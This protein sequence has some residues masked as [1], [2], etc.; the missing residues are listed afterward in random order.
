MWTTSM[1]NSLDKSRL[2]GGCPPR[3]L[4]VVPCVVL[5]LN[6]AM[7]DPLRGVDAR[8][9]GPPPDERTALSYV[10]TAPYSHQFMTAQLVQLMSQVVATIH[11][12]IERDAAQHDAVAV[13]HNRLRDQQLPAI[14]AR[15]PHPTVAPTDSR[16]SPPRNRWP[17]PE[18]SSLLTRPPA[19]PSQAEQD[20]SPTSRVA[21]ANLTPT[22]PQ[23][24]TAVPSSSPL[25]DRTLAS[26]AQAPCPTNQRAEA[27]TPTSRHITADP[28]S[29]AAASPS[30]ARTPITAAPTMIPAPPPSPAAPLN[31]PPLVTASASPRPPT[32]DCTQVTPQPTGPANATAANHRRISSNHLPTRLCSHADAPPIQPSEATTDKPTA[33]GPAPPAATCGTTNRHAHCTTTTDNTGR[34]SKYA[35]LLDKLKAERERDLTFVISPADHRDRRTTSSPA[36]PTTSTRTRPTPAAPALQV[37]DGCVPFT[38]PPTPLTTQYAAPSDSKYTS[39]ESS[40][41]TTVRPRHHTDNRPLTAP[42]AAT[43]STVTFPVQPSRY[44]PIAEEDDED[45][46]T[47]V[48]NNDRWTT[49]WYE[50]LP[51]AI[52]IGVALERAVETALPPTFPRDIILEIISGA[53]PG[54]K[55][56][57]A[58]IDEAYDKLGVGRYVYVPPPGVNAD[59]DDDPDD[60]DKKDIDHRPEVRE[61]V[62][63]S[64]VDCVDSSTWG[65]SLNG[66]GCTVDDNWLVPGLQSD[67]SGITALMASSGAVCTRLVLQAVTPLPRSLRAAIVGYLGYGAV[68]CATGRTAEALPNS[69]P[70]A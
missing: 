29:S 52:Q 9:H 31:A 6:C 40:S 22:T 39:A 3:V 4:V 12:L 65:S 20:S 49:R 19:Y 51:R 27:A 46:S 33:A 34:A 11:L 1:A 58:L 42:I 23:S 48:D 24:P 63:D 30:P 16:P 47:V 7:A 70:N 8:L 66:D 62:S 64:E 5:R 35:W 28:Y 15:T 61:C 32:T 68:N 13:A 41:W 37:N 17:S 14:A 44:Q 38:P 21:A 25:P 60:N 55:G 69:L 26:S 56:N 54:C 67:Y 43:T 45:D 57:S 10:S 50:S 59:D 53:R 2:V 36:A 18:Q